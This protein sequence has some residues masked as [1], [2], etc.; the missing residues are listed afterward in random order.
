LYEVNSLK[1]LTEEE[2]SLTADHVA[3]SESRISKLEETI[4]RSKLE[5][6]TKTGLMDK[7]LRI[8]KLQLEEA[9]TTFLE[10]KAEMA[11]MRVNLETLLHQEQVLHQNCREELEMTQKELTQVKE[12]TADDQRE[13]KKKIVEFALREEK[14]LSQIESVKLALSKKQQRVDELETQSKQALNGF[15][16]E[17]ERYKNTETQLRMQIN[18]LKSAV[19]EMKAQMTEMTTDEEKRLNQR[20]LELDE[21]EKKLNLE[22]KHLAKAQAEQKAEKLNLSPEELSKLDIQKLYNELKIA[23]EESHVLR[24]ER[25]RLLEQCNKAQSQLRQMKSCGQESARYSQVEKLQYEMT[26]QQ[27]GIIA[28]QNRGDYRSDAYSEE[29][30]T[31]EP[32]TN[33]SFFDSDL[34]SLPQFDASSI[35]SVEITPPLPKPRPKKTKKQAINYNQLRPK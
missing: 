6:E 28:L 13:S 21:R 20:N 24:N 15:D 34:T 26:K 33:D 4:E 25:N 27:L 2:R 1:L 14:F 8:R 19:S 9:K 16:G 5:T 32:T 12:L 10:E 31:R 11:Q 3:K 17:I 30:P 23:I 29:I 22:R 18:S 7:K 35:N